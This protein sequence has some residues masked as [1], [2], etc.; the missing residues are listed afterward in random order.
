M[1]TSPDVSFYVREICKVKQRGEFNA[2][3]KR[4][5]ETFLGNLPTAP[6]AIPAPPLPPQMYS[7]GPL[8]P[9]ASLM[10]IR[11][12][13]Q[14]DPFYQPSFMSPQPVPQAQPAGYH[15]SPSTSFAPAFT[16]SVPHVQ[17]YPPS[18]PRPFPS[19]EGYDMYA[20]RYV[21]PVHS[22][23]FSTTLL[24]T[25]LPPSQFTQQSLSRQPP[26]MHGSFAESR[27]PTKHGVLQESTDMRKMHEEI[28]NESYIGKRP[29]S[30]G[31]GLADRQ[32]GRYESFSRPLADTQFSYGGQSTFNSLVKF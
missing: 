30:A 8:D 23:T 24:Q 20:P 9:Y 6:A 10:K 15:S 28:L 25:S 3:M 19:A 18:P 11:Y 26:H 29:T 27:P 4:I 12:Q 32:S 14:P 21:E 17:P 2:L 31:V 16:Q 5:D 13:P 7:E 22:Q 1:Q